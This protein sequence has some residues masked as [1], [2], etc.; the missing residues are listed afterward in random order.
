MSS[1][2]LVFFPL[3]VK[4]RPIKLAAIRGLITDEGWKIQTLS[5]TVSNHKLIISECAL[6][7]TEAC[8]VI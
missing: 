7:W 6:W 3:P 4:T 2:F 8:D 1:Y 5:L